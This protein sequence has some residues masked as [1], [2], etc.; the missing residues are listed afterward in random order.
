MVS[1]RVRKFARC[2][3]NRARYWVRC[4]W[5][6]FTNRSPSRSTKHE[7]N[8]PM[9][10]VRRRRSPLG[11]GPLGS[12]AGGSRV[13]AGPATAAAGFFMVA[14][15]SVVACGVAAG[16]GVVATA[17]ALAGAVVAEGAG[18]VATAGASAGAVPAA[19]ASAA[20]GAEAAATGPGRRTVAEA[21]AA[22]RLAGR[23]AWRR[24]QPLPRAVARRATTPL[25]PAAA[26]LGATEY[27]GRS[28]VVS[29]GTKP[30]PQQAWVLGPGDLRPC[31][32]RCSHFPRR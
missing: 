26:S 10:R 18:G 20:G 30:S 25:V 7:F 19:G 8:T 9:R 22:G 2:F 32:C 17:G 6:T 4:S 1:P 15:A 5:L 29:C 13:G 16:S 12:S 3:S 28:S 31:R 23:L 11:W 21:P 14:C 27:L 24:Q